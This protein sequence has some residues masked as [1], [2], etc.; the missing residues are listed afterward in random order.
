M[1][2]K[3]VMHSGAQW[4][5]PDTPLSEIAKRMKDL[6]VGSIPVGE[7]DRLIGM[8]TDRD[9]A[10]RAVADGKD[11]SRLTARDVMS[12][13]IFYCRDTEDL[14]DALRIMEQKQVRRLPVINDEKRMVGILSVGDISH[15]AS[16]ELTG[17]AMTALSAHHA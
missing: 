17:E 14:E 6:D 16:H 15:A 11:C 7:N 13:G 10:C 3:D 1:K 8:V 12:E 5:G 4:V 9:I 2:V